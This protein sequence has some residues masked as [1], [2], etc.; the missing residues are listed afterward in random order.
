ME[1][2]IKDN[3]G[4]TRLEAENDSPEEYNSL[5]VDIGDVVEAVVMI[6]Y[7]SND[8]MIILTLIA[9]I[10]YCQWSTRESCRK[11]AMQIIIREERESSLKE[12]N[13]ELDQPR[14]TFGG[15]R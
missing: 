12:R 7:Y 14:T 13:T 3:A 10:H 5:E 2:Y 4:E 11:Q 9:V 6:R 15:I 1:L 8:G